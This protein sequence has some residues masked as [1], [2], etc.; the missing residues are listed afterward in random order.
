MKVY[1]GFIIYIRNDDTRC[2]FSMQPG[3]FHKLQYMSRQM[4]N[5]LLESKYARMVIEAMDVEHSLEHV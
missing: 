2:A 4:S 1:I 5:C 3:Q